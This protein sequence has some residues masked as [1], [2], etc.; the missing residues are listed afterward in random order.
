[1][2]SNEQVNE[3]IAN[4]IKETEKHLNDIEAECRKPDS[5]VGVISIGVGKVMK[6]YQI[7]A[8]LMGTFDGEPKNIGGFRESFRA[9]SKADK[10]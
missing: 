10:E 5:N 3:Y 6:N 2:F 8:Y 4:I 7:L 9:S 1:M